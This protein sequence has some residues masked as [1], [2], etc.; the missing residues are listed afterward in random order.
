MRSISVEVVV[1]VKVGSVDVDSVKEDDKVG[2]IDVG[3]VHD[4]S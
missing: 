2:V 1:E 4:R 3:A